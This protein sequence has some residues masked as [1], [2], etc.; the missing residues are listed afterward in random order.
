MVNTSA[1]PKAMRDLEIGDS[2]LTADWSGNVVF[3]EVAFFGHADP[4]QDG[5]YVHLHVMTGTGFAYELE[6][7]GQH[8]IL[9]SSEIGKPCAWDKSVMMHALDVVP[10]QHVWVMSQAHELEIATVLQCPLK[11]SCGLFNPFT[12]GGTTIIVDGVVAS[13][14]SAFILDDKVP[15][16]FLKYLPYL[17]QIAYSPC[18]FVYCLISSVF[19]KECTKVL[20]G[21]LEVSNPSP[22]G[23]DRQRVYKKQKLMVVVLWCTVCAMVYFCGFNEV[24]PSTVLK[25][26]HKT[27]QSCSSQQ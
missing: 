18:I 11:T 7:S 21:Y 16:S 22:G 8:F 20:A 26:P 25:V 14:H 9:V 10:G 27:F 1:G 19:G 3:D 23:A 24:L 6:L 4:F 2:V 15:Q 5:L 12:K 17:Y 13:T